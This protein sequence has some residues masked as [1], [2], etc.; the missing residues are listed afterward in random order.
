M[1]RK[2]EGKGITDLLKDYFEEPE[3]FINK[4]LTVKYQGLSADGIPRF[5]IGR[6]VRFDV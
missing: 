3:I 1:R 6:V 2:I 5:P 4:M